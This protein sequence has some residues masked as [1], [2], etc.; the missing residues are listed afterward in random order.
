MLKLVAAVKGSEKLLEE[1]QDFQEKRKQRKEDHKDFMA[2]EMQRYLEGLCV[3]QAVKV[4]RASMGMLD[5]RIVQINREAGKVT[6]I[7]PTKVMWQNIQSLLH[8]EYDADMIARM[9]RKAEVITVWANRI[10]TI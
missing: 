2:K 4:Y 9:E 3:G 10:R 8:K 6:V 7:N 1:G 5:T